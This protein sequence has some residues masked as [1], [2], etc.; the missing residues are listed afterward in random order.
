M[1]KYLI[2]GLS[3]LVVALVVG[4]EPVQRTINEATRMGTL[5]GAEICIDYSGSDILSGDAVKTMCVDAFQMPLF[6]SDFASGRAGP[7]V[8][9]DEVKWEGV[10]QNKTADHVTTW[11]EITVGFFDSD[12]KEERFKAETPIWIDPMDEAEFIVE[13]PKLDPERL[14]DITF[15]KNSDHSPK[16]CMSWGITAMKGLSI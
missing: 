8:E 14:D 3:C 12:G 4:V 7:R 11:I 13:L 15:C 1:E 16:S 6:H 9:Y 2:G 5:R 10:L